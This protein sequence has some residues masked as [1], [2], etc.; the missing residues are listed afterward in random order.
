MAGV[1][2]YPAG[3]ISFFEKDTII[4]PDNPIIHHHSN[5]AK[6]YA[7]GDLA[8]LGIMPDGF[9]EELVRAIKDSITM[10]AVRKRNLLALLGLSTS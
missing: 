7:A 3:A 1:V 9:V 4:P 8:V 6:Q 5:L 10:S 2:V